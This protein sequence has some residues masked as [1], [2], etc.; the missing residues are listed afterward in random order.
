M[1]VT[2]HR[3]KRKTTGGRYI[4]ARKKRL[5]EKGRDPT[6]TKLGKT[7][8]KKVRT[9]GGNIKISLLKSDT[10]NLFDP[11]TKTYCK[12]KIKS[13]LENP[14]NRHFIRRNILTK[15]A[16]IETEKGRAKITSRPGQ[17]GS[18]NAILVPKK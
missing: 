12:V 15:G 18:I 5:F 4:A 7:K 17:E 13:V 8:K 10:A 6:L 2:H 3:S 11:E 9:K 14:A 1:V 16:V